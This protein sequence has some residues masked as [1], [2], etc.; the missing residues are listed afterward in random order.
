MAP[1]SY[2]VIGAV[3]IPGVNPLHNT[4]IKQPYRLVGDI[5]GLKLKIFCRDIFAEFTVMLYKQN[6]G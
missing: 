5:A 2:K 4:E 3:T 6:S 1:M